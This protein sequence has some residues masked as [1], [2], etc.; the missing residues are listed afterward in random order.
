[1]THKITNIILLIHPSSTLFPFTFFELPEGILHR[2]FI[3]NPSDGYYSLGFAAREGK[4]V[5]MVPDTS[6]DRIRTTS[7]ECFC[8][9]I[10]KELDPRGPPL[11]DEYLLSLTIGWNL[12]IKAR[13][14][15][16]KKWILLYRP[17][18]A[19]LLFIMIC[20]TCICT[21]V[22][23]S[24]DTIFWRIDVQCYHAYSVQC[25]LAYRC[26]ILPVVKERL[27]TLYTRGDHDPCFSQ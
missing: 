24:S 8:F 7:D 3:W 4:M 11:T 18:V 6:N 2:T 20:I 13:K 14:E 16:E 12:I 21:I 9:Q 17:I 5:Y 26:T 19:E 27:L 10:Q 25:Y 23:S 15:L 22:V 1:M